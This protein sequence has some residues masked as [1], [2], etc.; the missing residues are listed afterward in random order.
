MQFKWLLWH[1][2]G[3]NSEL[4]TVRPQIATGIQPAQHLDQHTL[5]SWQNYPLMLFAVR[6]TTTAKVER[7][8]KAIHSISRCLSSPPQKWSGLLLESLNA[9]TSSFAEDALGGKIL[10][11]CWVHCVQVRISTG[12]FVMSQVFTIAKKAQATSFFFTSLKH[13][14]R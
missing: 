9:D 4:P 3:Q 5:M 8:N 13:Q 7:N 1:P 2:E 6:W 10:H 14:Q 12:S 11:S